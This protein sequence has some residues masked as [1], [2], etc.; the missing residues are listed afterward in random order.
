MMQIHTS[1]SIT[2]RWLVSVAER[3][4][5]ERRPDLGKVGSSTDAVTETGGVVLMES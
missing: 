1:G 5:P 4:Y 2:A 3:L